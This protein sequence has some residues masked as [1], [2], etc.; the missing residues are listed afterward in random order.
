MPL[1]FS[2]PID[3]AKVFS[4]VVIAVGSVIMTV[5]AW[6]VVKIILGRTYLWSFA[7]MVRDRKS[8]V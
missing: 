1:R 6:P 3:K 5:K 8:V 2:R 7:T 4:T